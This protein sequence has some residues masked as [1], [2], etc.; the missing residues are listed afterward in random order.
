MYEVLAGFVDQLRSAGLPVSTSEAIDAARAVAA[1]NVMERPELHAALAS[2]LVKNQAHQPSFNVIFDTYFAEATNAPGSPPVAAGPAAGASGGAEGGPLGSQTDEQLMELLARSLVGGDDGLIRLLAAEGVSRYAQL[3]PGRPAGVLLYTHRTLRGL[4]LSGVLARLK[5]DTPA[6]AGL[7]GELS[8]LARQL[9]A[10]R[11]ERHAQ[12]FREEV[13]SQIRRRLVADRGADAVVRTL[14]IPLPEDIEFMRANSEQMRAMQRAIDPLARKLAEK[15]ALRQ[16]AHHHGALNMPA[17][18]R[19]SLEWGGVPLETVTRRPKAHKPQIVVL[20][21]ISGSVAAFAG[22]T[23][24]FVSAMSAKVARVRSFMFV[25]GVD[26]V[27]GHVNRN[28]SITEALALIRDNATLI[29][30]DGHTDYG[31]VFEVF[32]DR[33]G[34]QLT[35][36]TNVLILGDARSNYRP[37][38]VDA[39]RAIERRSARVLWLNPESKEYWNTGDS[40]IGAYAPYCA[41]VYECRTIRQLSYVASLVD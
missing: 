23:L 22:F 28:V 41:G 14:R 32:T 33:W 31:H 8:S 18:M 36:R 29:A 27:T 1:I 5:D 4:D 37:P 35:R 21:D 13:E 30:G 25:D 10:R 39:L 16:R 9:W 19:R 6:D 34:P 24:Q 38:C 40:I 11:L 2:T 26:E 15:M 20:A 17:T 7:P 12:R 3:Q